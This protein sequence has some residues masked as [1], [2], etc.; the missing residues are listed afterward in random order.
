MVLDKPKITGFYSIGKQ[1]IQ[2]GNNGVDLSQV[3]RVYRLV[4][5]AERE[6]ENIP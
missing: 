6:I 2:E 3:C 1:D 5:E 4:N